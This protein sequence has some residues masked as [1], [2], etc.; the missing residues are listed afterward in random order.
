MRITTVHGVSGVITSSIAIKLDVTETQATEAALRAT[1]IKYRTMIEH[2]N[3][4]IAVEQDGKIVY[5]NLLFEHLLGHS[6]DNTQ[7]VIARSFLD[8]VAQEDRTRS[9]EYS[10]QRLRGEPVPDHYEIALRALHGRR[11]NVE[12]KPRWPRSVVCLIKQPAIPRSE[13]RAEMRQQDHREG[14]NP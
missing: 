1:E 11:I 2:A 13:A 7:V 3:D 6:S 9:R 5:C 4:A 14:D 8:S 10:Q 12:I